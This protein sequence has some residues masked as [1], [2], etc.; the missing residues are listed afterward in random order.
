MVGKKRKLVA[1]A[2]AENRA[3]P[4]KVL[5]ALAIAG[6]LLRRVPLGHLLAALDGFLEPR[7]PTNLA[8]YPEVSGSVGGAQTA[9][10]SS[11]TPRHRGGTRG[12][13]PPA[14]RGSSGPEQCL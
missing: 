14:R 2:S 5:P 4:G 13:N 6:E 1:R 3:H 12:G 8:G 9:G 10:S 7:S 11:P